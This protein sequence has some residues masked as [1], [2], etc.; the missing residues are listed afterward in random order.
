[1][2][3]A[4]AVTQTSDRRISAQPYRLFHVRVLRLH[5]LSPSFLR[6][7]FT[8][9]D[10]DSFA[11]NGFDQR[12]K[13]VLPLPVHGVRHMPAEPDWYPL[14]RA[15]PDELRNPIRTY[16]VRAVRQRSREVDVDVVLHGDGGPAARWAAA[17]RVG[18]G[19]ALIGPDARFPGTNGGV[20]FQLPPHADTVLLAGDETAL[21]AIAAILEGLERRSGPVRGEAVIEVPGR[22]DLLHLRVP[23]GVRVTWLAREGRP[24]GGLLVPA[25]KRAADRLLA[26]VR[27]TGGEPVAP[28]PADTA[29]DGGDGDIW[30]VPGETGSAGPRTAGG[31]Y[32]WLAG[33]AGAI[34]ALRR[35]LVGQRGV[36]RRSVAFMGY[37]R[38]GR[39]EAN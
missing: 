5:R 3:G 23:A 27:H 15:L 26:G 28:S 14:W 33:E 8:G 9:G 30:E 1:M 11:D 17:V 4:R 16:T 10:L 20:A 37:W 2:P 38:L 18:D 19:L 34:Q 29:G 7:T 31:I 35:H 21:P 24:H 13:L 39:A 12:I 32:T 25:V 22:A 36:D 6:V